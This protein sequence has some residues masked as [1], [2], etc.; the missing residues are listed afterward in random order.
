MTQAFYVECSGCTEHFAGHKDDRKICEILAKNIEA[1]YEA[2][3]SGIEQDLAS[4]AGSLTDATTIASTGLNTP[5]LLEDDM[6][7]SEEANGSARKRRKTTAAASSSAGKKPLAKSQ[8]KAAQAATDKVS[9]SFQQ[10]PVV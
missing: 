10:N 9:M 8:R 1:E 7:P 3:M 6:E 4:R 2:K 5:V